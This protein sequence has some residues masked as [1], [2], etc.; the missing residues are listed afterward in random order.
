[1]A[2]DAKS[3]IYISDPMCSWCWGF[4]PVVQRIEEEYRGQFA[5]EPVLG[6]LRPGTTEPLSDE[7]RE[8]LL[9]HWHE[10]HEATGQPFDF[11]CNLPEGFAYDTEPACRAT[12]VVRTLKPEAAL[13]YLRA[14]HR[15]FYAENRDV[16]SEDVL[17]ELAQ[18]VGI[19]AAQFREEFNGEAAKLETRKD[20]VRSRS[21]GVNGFPALVVRNGN[22]LK[23]I[24]YG[25]APYE[26]LK[27]RIATW[28]NETA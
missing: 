14:V 11:S 13:E 8:T 1:M 24:T 27:P 15:A 7:W 6:G 23:L 12:V 17:A 21:M 18:G 19:D 16:T 22:R 26:Q 9:H 5:I 4:S 28:L 20:F 25:Y 2:A 10:V 3:L